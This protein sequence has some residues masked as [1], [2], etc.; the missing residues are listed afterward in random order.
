MLGSTYSTASMVLCM[1]TITMVLLICG[2]NPISRDIYCNS[3]SFTSLMSVR[4]TSI[5]LRGCLCHLLLVRGLCQY[6]AGTGG[7]GRITLLDNLEKSDKVKLIRIPF[8]VNL[9]QNILIIVISQRSTQFVVVHVWFT[10]PFTPSS[11]DVVWIKELEFPVPTVPCYG[12]TV[13]RVGQ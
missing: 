13:G 12:H 11:G 10:F 6:G 4:I 7:V 3:C 5:V 8:A 9:R 1:S 2:V